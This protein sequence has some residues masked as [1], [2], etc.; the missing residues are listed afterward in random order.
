MIK[1]PL[2]TLIEGALLPYSCVHFNQIPQSLIL[3]APVVTELKTLALLLLYYISFS[4]QK[5]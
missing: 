5:S 2:H 1:F 3:N 4:L